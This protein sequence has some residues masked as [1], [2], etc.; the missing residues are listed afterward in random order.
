MCDWWTEGSLN[1]LRGIPGSEFC[2]LT[3]VYADPCFDPS[4]MDYLIHGAILSDCEIADFLRRSPAAKEAFSRQ[5]QFLTPDEQARLHYILN[6]PGRDPYIDDF[7]YEQ[8]FQDQLNKNP[9]ILRL[10][11]GPLAPGDPRRSGRSV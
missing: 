2:E 6:G 8:N 7:V 4:V 3:G 1:T 9:Q 10:G 11:P 5:V